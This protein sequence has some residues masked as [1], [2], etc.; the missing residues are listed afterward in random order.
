[1]KYR[2]IHSFVLMVMLWIAPAAWGAE[3]KLTFVHVNDVYELQPR[4]G[5]GGV[6]ALG[7]LL[8]EYRKHHP[9]MIFTF[10]GD[11]LS[12]SLLSGVAQGRQMIEAMN[13]LG[14]EVAVPGNHEFDF[15]PEP[16]S[17]QLRN[18]RGVWLA[19]NMA[20]SDG[21][22]VPG[23]RRQLI[24]DID[25]I[26]VGFFGLITP[27]TAHTSK[28]G[29]NIVF[30]PFLE[31]A[32]KEVIDLK[33]K[34]VQVIVAMT[35]LSLAEDRQLASEIKGI[36]LILGGHDHDPIAIHEHGVLI[37]KSGSDNRYVSIVELIANTPPPGQSIS[38]QYSWQV[39]PVVGIAPDPTL[40]SLVARWQKTLDDTLGEPLVKVSQP[41][42]T[43]EG[44][45][46]T[47][48][49]P[50]GNLVT[51]AMRQAVGGEVALMNGGGLRGNRTYPAGYHFTAKDILTELPFGNV[52]VLLDVK[53]KDLLAVLERA[54]S[55]VEHGA[56]RFPQVSGLTFSFDP[57]RT[58]GQ[59]ILAV[60]VGAAPLDSE[61]S[62]RVATTDYLASGKD[63]YDA[64]QRG[65]LRID[66][67]AATLVSNHV[68]EWLLAHKE[69]IPR[70]EGRIIA[71]KS[72]RDAQ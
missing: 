41:F 15:G 7:T 22:L 21:T 52:T 36:D 56:G 11:L 23:T 44:S 10:G 19:S 3:T 34:G 60:R 58:A 62:Y 26:K 48:E 59:R 38:L 17:Q 46:R 35:H 29:P 14:M 6:A 33:A 5:M 37:I 25:G 54:V 57:T 67:S 53:G 68:K 16:M 2:L 71:T 39:R 72:L 61:R 31:T 47:R 1:M 24:R 9:R 45:V 49:N 13:A 32:Q 63:G 30:A 51:D 28:P 8:Q 12:P 18:S 66:P 50:L 27:D 40:V 64:L 69:W 65:T 70:I 43:L 42:D 55:Q 4:H 20:T